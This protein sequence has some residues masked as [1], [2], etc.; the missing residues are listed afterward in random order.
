MPFEFGLHFISVFTDGFQ[1]A[2]DDLVFGFFAEATAPEVVEND[3][4]AAHI[5]RTEAPRQFVGIVVNIGGRNRKVVLLVEIADNPVSEIPAGFA[6]VFD[7][8]VYL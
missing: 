5:V 4:D 2:V 3:F 8:C 7:D 1:A 6:I